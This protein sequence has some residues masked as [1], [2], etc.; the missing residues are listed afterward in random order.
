MNVEIV[1]FLESDLDTVF[2]IQKAA[3]LPL[4]EKYRDDDTSPY[5]ESRESV[6]RKY[7]R[8]GTVGYLFLLDGAAVGAVR[9]NLEKE[10]GSARISALCVL[11]QV[12]GRGI[13]QSALR[14][15]EKLH[16]HIRRW[17]LSTILEEKG[18]CHLYEK[19]GYR[20]TG[21][22]VTVN[23]K[24]TL[25]YYEKSEEREGIPMQV[26]DEI[27][28]LIAGKEYTCDE[29]GMSGSKILIFDDFVLKIVSRKLEDEDSAVRVM[30][31]LEGKIPV[32]KVIAYEK[33]DKDQYL[34]MSKVPG[35]MSCDEYYLER[36]KELLSLLAQALR[37]LWSIDVSGCPR[38]RSIDAELEEAKYRVENHL[39]DLDNA[40]PDTFGEGGFADPQA[41][42][43]WLHDHKP[44][45]DPVLSHGDFC[46]PNLFIENGHVSGLI[47]L[48]E[49]GVGDRWRD[50]ALCW[51]SLKHN[52]DG[53]Y[54]G[55]VYPDF[56]PDLLFDALGIEPDRE[57]LRFSLLLDEL[58]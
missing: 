43:E 57:K 24:M 35:R 18:N 10:N 46:L 14:K 38:E 28:K 6:L 49:T 31:W 33:D 20:K 58:F 56:D 51:R 7:T 39:V 47:D 1:R 30:R 53:T 42:L 17:S 19:I 27:G 45:Y 34:L 50:I 32:P 29:T 23:D 55:K 5:K 13:A 37:L 52:F 40:E 4:Y 26:P 16:P 21:K 22:T 11:P 48:G 12:Q 9:V 2:E 41:L 15:I 8:E 25:V 44:E 54:G 3:F 36:P